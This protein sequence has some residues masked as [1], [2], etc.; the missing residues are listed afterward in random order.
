MQI[1]AQAFS[2]PKAG[3]SEA[4]YEDA[5][6]PD[7][8]YQRAAQG[9]FRC[10]VADGAT[11]TSYSR[12]WAHLLVSAFANDRL[13]GPAPEEIAALRQRWGRGVER[14]LQGPRPWYAEQK[15]K[16][17]A[18]AAL[19]TLDV[20]ENDAG[21]GQWTSFALGDSCL[22]QIRRDDLLA[23]FP[24]V[25]SA[26]FNDR[27]RLI[28]STP[29]DAIETDDFRRS[30]GA[31]LA[32]DTFYLMS[33]AIA[34]WFFKQ[35]EAGK[36]PWESLRDLGTSAMPGFRSWLEGLRRET[37]LKNDDVTVLRVDILPDARG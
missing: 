36:R 3:A 31:W 26:E 12:S 28:G 21:Q 18:F 30:E 14:R 32:E 24:L 20:H 2:A 6:W 25:A 1:F 16:Q 23:A 17:G 22:V 8:I 4:E 15:A 34:C 35:L 7:G 27:P 37:A 5:A 19:V 29:N 10:A 9:R 11:E 33:D 13:A